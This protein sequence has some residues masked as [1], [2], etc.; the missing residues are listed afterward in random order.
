MFASANFTLNGVRGRIW[1][2]LFD[3]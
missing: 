1:I 3:R 2:G